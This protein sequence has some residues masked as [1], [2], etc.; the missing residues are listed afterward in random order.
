MSNETIQQVIKRNAVNFKLIKEK[1]SPNELYK[2]NLK[3]YLLLFEA[4]LL[5]ER[6]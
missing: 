3:N 6:F 4:T 2:R 1:K 5:W